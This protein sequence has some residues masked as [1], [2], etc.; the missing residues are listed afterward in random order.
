MED[1][2][3]QS[4]NVYQELREE[5]LEPHKI[6]QEEKDAELFV[7]ELQHKEPIHKPGMVAN[8][9]KKESIHTSNYKLQVIFKGKFN[10]D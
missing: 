7:H 2:L 3:F 10:F 9:K 1:N 6:L 4:S 8:L 5:G